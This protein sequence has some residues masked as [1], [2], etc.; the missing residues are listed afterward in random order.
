MNRESEG[1]SSGIPHLAKNERDMG[2]P[3]FARERE[4]LVVLKAIVFCPIDV[5]AESP[6]LPS[7][8]FFRSL[9]VLQPVKKISVPAIS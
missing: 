8:E 7:S 6:D 3:S 2:H 1:K 9:R 4:A 5:R